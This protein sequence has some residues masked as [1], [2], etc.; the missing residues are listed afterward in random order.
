MGPHGVGHVDTD[1]SLVGEVGV[2]AGAVDTDPD[3]GPTDRCRHRV[4]LVCEEILGTETGRGRE[5]ATDQSKGFDRE[6]HYGR[7]GGRR[8]PQT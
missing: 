7:E 8:G 5:L 2:G 3:R 4:L 6:G 1:G